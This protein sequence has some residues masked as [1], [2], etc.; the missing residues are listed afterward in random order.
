MGRGKRVR[1][2]VKWGKIQKYSM[3]PIKIKIQCGLFFFYAKQNY[4]K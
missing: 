4:N 1:L 3:H 2:P